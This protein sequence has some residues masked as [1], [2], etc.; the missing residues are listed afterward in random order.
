M[1][2]F[3]SRKQGKNNTDT[4]LFL[5]K[6]RNNDANNDLILIKIRSSNRTINQLS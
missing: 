1:R 2:A 4:G 6:K 5:I 3:N